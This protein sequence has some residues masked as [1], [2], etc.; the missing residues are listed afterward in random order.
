MG[1]KGSGRSQD[2]GTDHAPGE[3]PR[4]TQ[5]PAEGEGNL[6]CIVEGDNTYYLFMPHLSAAAV[7]ALVRLTNHALSSFPQKTMPITV[8]E[9]LFPDRVNVL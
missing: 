6:E 3:P 4:P 9:M 7:E 8:L 1:T 5:V 2:E